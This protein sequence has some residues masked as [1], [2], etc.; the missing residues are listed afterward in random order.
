LISCPDQD[1]VKD[2][3]KFGFIADALSDS[4]LHSAQFMGV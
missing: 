4:A 3:A 1:F 2:I